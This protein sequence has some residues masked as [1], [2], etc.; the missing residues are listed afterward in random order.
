MAY[1]GFIEKLFT[2]NATK[3]EFTW[4]STRVTMGFETSTVKF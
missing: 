1:Q 2:K 3:H 4:L